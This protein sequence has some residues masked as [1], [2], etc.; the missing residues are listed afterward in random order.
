MRGF[1]FSA[2]QRAEGEVPDVWVTNPYGVDCA[3]YP[4]TEEGCRKLMQMVESW[5]DYGEASQL[6]EVV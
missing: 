6:M 1:N 4:A 3:M 5:V 2:E